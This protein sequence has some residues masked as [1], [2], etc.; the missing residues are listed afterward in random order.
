MESSAKRLEALSFA[1]ADE[2][3]ERLDWADATVQDAIYNCKKQRKAGES[4]ASAHPSLSAASSAPAMLRALRR[5]AENSMA[6]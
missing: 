1:D 3:A 2:A 4:L 5:L 6:P